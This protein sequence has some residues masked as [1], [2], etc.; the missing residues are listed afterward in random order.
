MIG[1]EVNSVAQALTEHG[2][3]VTALHNHDAP[4]LFSCTSG[5]MIPLR[6]WRKA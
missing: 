3:R 2:I 1:K 6:M 5:H 4:D